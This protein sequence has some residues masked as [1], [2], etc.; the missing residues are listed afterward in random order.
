MIAATAGSAGATVA[1]VASGDPMARST[2]A[3]SRPV[4]VPT[5]VKSVI[6]E[7]TVCAR[8]SL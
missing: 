7:S 4:I 5:T 8:S 3:R 6:E 2:A 1:L